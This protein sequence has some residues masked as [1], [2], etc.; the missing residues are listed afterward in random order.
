MA[1]LE[2]SAC[3]G[4]DGPSGYQCATLRVPL[5]PAHPGRRTIGLALDRRKATGHVVG[6][7]LVNPGGPGVSGVNTLPGIASILSPRLKRHFDVIGFDP[8]GVGHSDPVTCLGASE[9]GSYLR[10][11]PS[12]TTSAGFASLV[13][14]DRSF[15]AGCEARSSAILPYVGT[16]DAA[17]DMDYIRAALGE[18]KLNYLGFSYGTFLGATYAGLFPTH[19]RAM[20]LDGALDPALGPIATVREQSQSLYKQFQAFSANC[21]AHSS[22]AWHPGGSLLGAYR[23]L[24]AR[25]RSHP[26]PAPGSAHR[27]GQGVL[28]YGTA[29]ALYTPSSW[30]TLASALEQ[31]EQGNGTQIMGLFDGYVG[32]QSGGT[33][34]NTTEAETAVDCLDA[35]APSLSRIRA[36][37]PSVESVAPLFGLLDLYS[38]A[39]CTVWPVKATSSPHVIKAAGSP[40]IVVVGSTGDPITPYAWAQALARQLANGVLLTR[41]GYGH[42]GYEAS[43][44]VR[45]NVDTYFLTLRVPKVGT[46]CQSSNGLAGAN[47]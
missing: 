47:G 30:P 27:V 9:L 3:N 18:K 1:P 6:S 14:L 5:D 13:S 39:S 44:C 40:P 21:S 31:A 17:I 33:Y 26:I 34:S 46:R 38:E 37:A 28:L 43:A 10:A 19:V 36:A 29:A 11:D 32:R 20:V 22:C 24:L 41:V 23:S 8:P 42:T 4:A 15:A 16:R 12:P 35:P 25:V 2:W 45:S 7:L